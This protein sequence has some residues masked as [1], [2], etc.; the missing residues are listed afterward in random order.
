MDKDSK[1]VHTV[2]ATAANVH[3]VTEVP[4]LL[5]GEEEVVYG[6]SGY[7]GADK[8]ED[9]VLRNKSDRKIKYKINR[10]PSQM[11]NSSTLFPNL[12]SYYKITVSETQFMYIVY[13]Q[14]GNLSTDF[15]HIHRATALT[16]RKYFQMG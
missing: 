6:D 2:E 8:R 16:F 12:D 3:D 1:L 14:I 15:Q 5:T 4:K 11:K 13:T 7:L 10:R 9:A